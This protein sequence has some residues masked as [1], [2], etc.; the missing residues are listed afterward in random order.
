MAHRIASDPGL[1]LEGV[2]CH[3]PCADMAP[4]EI[5]LQQIAAFHAVRRD[6]RAA[7][8]T[9][10][11]FHCANSAAIL[12]YPDA[13]F[14]AVRP[15]ISL[16]G[17]YPSS[18]IIHRVDLRPAMTL[19]TRVVYIKDVPAGTGLS[20]GHAFVTCRA[21]RIATVP[22]GYADGYP[23]HASNV[24]VMM[25]RGAAARQVGRVCMDLTL[26]DVTDIGG[27]QIGDE[28]LVF[29]PSENGFLPADAVAA[30]CGTIGYEITTRIG[31]RLPRF[32]V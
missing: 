17:Q 23:R 8:L 1:V 18:G 21:S 29:G 16:Y 22:I 28:V 5:T 10:R 13:H 9:V 4:T 14:D 2:M 6:L 26:L 24:A 15:G 31:K 7:G 20:Y 27:V 19:K 11:Y 30:A 25:V 3:L 32:Y 12:D